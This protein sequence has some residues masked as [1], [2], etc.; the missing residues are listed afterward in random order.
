MSR[1]IIALLAAASL[2][3]GTM[4]APLVGGK[5]IKQLN[6]RVSI[7]SG[8][9]RILFED[10]FSTQPAGSQPSP[11]KWVMQTGTGYPGGPTTWGTNEVET[12]T[13]SR[14]N[15]VITSSGTLLITPLNNGGRW[16]SSRI[17]TVSG[18]F[19]CP[20]GDKLRIEASLRFGS[21]PPSQQM[22]IWPSF[23]AMGSDFRGQYHLWPAVGEIDIAESI[24]GQPT[25]WNALHCGTAPGG[26]CNEYSGISSTGAM[27]RGDFHT[28]AVEIDRTNAGGDWRGETLK[29]FVDG[30][31]TATV[32]SARVSDEKAWTA[33][34]RNAKFL[35]LNVAVGGDFTDNVANEGFV[36]T[37]TGQ[38]A[39]GPGA[40]LEVR[41]IAVFST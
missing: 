26:P 27:S 37:P 9:S 29:W 22:G 39:G 15:V 3:D 41:Y 30:R 13:T 28:V 20:A 2:L 38:T 34:T 21:A 40:S 35:I 8:F 1:L 19:R 4:A 7:P 33:V 5:I 36:H 24:N 17:E 25:V 10:D 23:W 16:T 6:R 14:D 12:Y 11:S 32:S 18:D 31:V